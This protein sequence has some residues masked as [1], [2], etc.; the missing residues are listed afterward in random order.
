[1]ASFNF[2]TDLTVKPQQYGTGLADIVNMAKGVQAYQKQAATMPAEIE[3]AKAESAKSQLDLLKNQISMAG[4]AITGLENSDSY[5]NDD[6]KGL[7]KELSATKQWT[8]TF[9]HSP[10]IDSLY[11]QAES[12]LNDG[13]IAGYKSFLARI[14]NS[15]ASNS[16]KYSAALPQVKEINQLPFIFK[17]AQGTVT[18][19]TEQGTQPSAGGATQPSFGGGATSGSQAQM[20]TIIP[21][22]IKVMTGPGG[23]LN[24][25]EKALYNEG[26]NLKG[27][28]TSQALDASEGKQT[29]RKIKE[30]I[31][32]AAGS[33]PGQALRSAGKWI[34]GNEEL[35]TLTKNLADLQMRNAKLMGVDTDA[36]RETGKIAS[37]SENI[38]A[39]ALQG[40]VDRADATNSAVIAFNKG[41]DNYEG[42]RS[43]N[44]AYINARQFKQAWADNYD[45]KIFMIQNIN[46][47][48]ASEAQK[49]LERQKVLKGISES[50]MNILRKK[51]ENIKRLEQ[52][53]Y[54]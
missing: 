45:P 7:K 4:G 52:G 24:E 17:Q 43:R 37:G 30:T 2:D 54:Q 48:D 39:G 11:Q 19:L 20:P 1:M 42:K 23:V 49:Q 3:Q 8:S 36:A 50:E 40:I 51:A 18:P 46:R 53:N 44:H 12:H 15:L 26:A 41:L 14:R 38:T 31:R 29:I 13:D 6:I 28:S 34:A 22:E 10:A 25:Q 16:E 27:Q 9:G 5:K 35:D 33:A 47:S 21:N 32:S